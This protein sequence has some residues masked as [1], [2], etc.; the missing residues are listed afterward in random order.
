MKLADRILRQLTQVRD[1]SDK[2]L[3]AF[4]SPEDWTHQLAPGTNHAL[5]FAG[6]MAAS[7]NWMISMVAPER[8]KQMDEWNALFGTGSQPTSDPDNYPPPAEVL[9][10]MRER[11][12]V[13]IELLK[14]S[15]DKELAK[16]SPEAIL[17][18]CPDYGAIF[19][20]TAWH[21]ALHAGQVTLIRRALGHAP[22]FSAAPAETSS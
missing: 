13:L 22:L 15:S 17:D 21:E 3:E 10:A 9:D 6:H 5:W 1:M 8:A 2:L 7:D 14:G 18:F 12:G 11:R 4:Q 20:S 16:A 19:E